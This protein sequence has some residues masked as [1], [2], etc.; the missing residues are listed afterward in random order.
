MPKATAPAAK[1]ETSLNG[2]EDPRNIL[3][4]LCAGQPLAVLATAAGN[5]PYTSLVAIAMTPDLNRLYFATLRTTR[6]WQNL[7]GN[8]QV[9]LLIDNRSDPQAAAIAHG[10]AAT[11]LGAA[12]ELH[13]E[14]RAAGLAIYLARHPDLAEFAAAPGCALFRVQV[15]SISL[16]TRFQNVVE[17]AF[18]S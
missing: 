10:I 3:Q 8:R 6:K 15:T 7:T 14:D 16:V 1:G 2:S 4:D 17:F 12:E 11:V 9:A 5:A 13:G 18:P